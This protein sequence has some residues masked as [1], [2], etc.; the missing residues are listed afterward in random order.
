MQHQ[1]PVK[2]CQWSCG[3]LREPVGLGRFGNDVSEAG[4]YFGCFDVVG[5]SKRD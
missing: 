3:R 1:E 4:V 5:K 2:K